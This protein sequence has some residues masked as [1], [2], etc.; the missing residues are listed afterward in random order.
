[1][2]RI[3]SIIGLVLWGGQA[4]ALSCV[5]LTPETLF[6]W[7]QQADETFVPVYGEITFD[8]ALVQEP[9]RDVLRPRGVTYPAQFDGRFVSSQGFGADISTPITVNVT[10]TASWCGGVPSQGLSLAVLERTDGGLVLNQHACPSSHLPQPTKADL[11][12]FRAC[13]RGD[14]CNANF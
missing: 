8:P 5:Q 9:A 6:T 1:M 7:A 10:C 14:V 2:K 13:L 11:D 12:A 3:A 4:V